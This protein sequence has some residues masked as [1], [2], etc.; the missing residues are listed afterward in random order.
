MKKIDYV[1]RAKSPLYTG[2]GSTLGIKSELRKQKVKIAN[3]IVIKSKFAN[4]KD[5][6]HALIDVLTLLYAE[7]SPDYR[8]KR[9]SDIWKEFKSGVLSCC[10]S[11]SI[12]TFMSR[13]ANRFDVGHFDTGILKYLELYSDIEFLQYLTD[14]VDYLITMMR[15]NREGKNQ[16]YNRIKA[17]EKEI[18]SLLEILDKEKDSMFFD[19]EPTKRQIDELWAEQKQ[20]ELNKSGLMFDINNYVVTDNTISY[21]KDFEN[22]PLFS[23]N[24]IGGLMRRLAMADYLS[25]IGVDSMFDYTYHTLFTGGTLT[26]KINEEFADKLSQFVENLQDKLRI[27]LN[28]KK[29][30]EGTNDEIVPESIER[31]AWHCPPLRLFGSATKGGMIESEMIVSNARLKCKENGNG[32]VTLWSLIE[33]VFYTRKDSEKTERNFEILDTSDETH[34][35]K[36]I[37]ETLIEGTEFEHNFVLRSDNQYIYDCFHATLKLFAEYHRIGG[38]SARGLGDIDLSELVAQIDYEAVGRYY[39]HLENHKQEMKGYLGV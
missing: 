25:K 18:K 37:M 10:G 31:L 34:Q 11:K 1:F 29:Q 4:E 5:R 13:F 3:P 38:K 22:V 23:G 27:S 26:D 32:D 28:A 17:L 21:Q 16:N 14:N 20:L 19:A 33:D 35:M 2:A 15:L 6:E 36:Y 7:I 9:G 39:M 30:M 24:S 12:S 8:L